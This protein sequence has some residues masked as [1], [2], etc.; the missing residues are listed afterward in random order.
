MDDLVARF[1]RVIPDLWEPHPAPTESSIAHINSHFRLALP[2]ALYDLAK[3]STRFSNIFLSF[4]ENYEAHNHVIPYNRYWRTRRRTRKLPGNFIIITCGFMDEDF[5]CI[6]RD[7]PDGMNGY[8]IQFWSPSPVGYPGQGHL[9]ERLP[10]VEALIDKLLN[11]K[12]GT[13][14]ECFS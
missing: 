4:G 1:D 2:R 14:D 3:Q 11:T 8:E 5:W 10:G 9:G 12:L 7:A 13:T 6:D